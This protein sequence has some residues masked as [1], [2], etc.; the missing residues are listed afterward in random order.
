MKRHLVSLTLAASVLAST[1]LTAGAAEPSP[2]P[3]LPDTRFGIAEGF[4]NPTAMADIRAGWQRLVFSWSDIQPNGP[5]DFSQLGLS[6]PNDRLQAELDRGSRVAGLLQFTPGWAQ[7]NPG[8]GQRSVPLNLDLPFDDPN[9]Y[10]GRYVYETVKYYNGRINEWIIWNEP[11]FRETDAGAGGSFTWKGTDEEFAQ[12]LKVGYLA[13]K[14][15]NPNATVSFPGTS[16]WVEELASPRRPQF[17]DRVLDILSRDPEAARNNQYHD[18]VSLNLY[19]APDDVFRVHAVFKAIQQKYG[20]DKPIWLTETNAMPSDDSSVPCANRHADVPIKTTMDQQASYAMQ[21][22]ALAAAAGYQRIEFYQMVDGGT[23]QEPAIWG[24]TR[25]NGSRRPVADALRTSVSYYSGYT[26]AQ[27]V[28][29]AREVQR[30]PT[31]PDDPSSY[32]PNW[33]VYQVA[34][35][36]PGSQRVT[37]LWN[38]DGSALRARIKKTGSSARVVERDGSERPLLENQG[39]W[40]VDL[41]AAT[42]YFQLNDVIKDPEGFYF[43]GGQPLLIV[44]EGVA[45]AAPVTQPRLGEP[46]SAQRDFNIVVSPMDQSL[47]LGEPAEFYLSS[48]GREDFSDPIQLRVVSW[49]S[50]RFPDPKDGSSLPLGVSLQERIN[51]GDEA[52][53][54]LET[55]GADPGIYYITLEASGG[56]ITRTMELALA[57]S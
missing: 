40:V 3:S 33:Q 23:C 9:N 16:Y 11:E 45:A 7:R 21:S 53:L 46:G 15:A 19:R 36:R 37:A 38:G 26:Q 12:L 35:D 27:F 41:P 30:W 25:D 28:P 14:R 52:T 13:A 54:R 43:I 4:R 47:G 1:A 31:W 34:F 2:A 6:L 8:D 24:V 5:G 57:L 18:V 10:F 49:S 29:L 48:F 50:Q 20:L 17:Y 51:P 55:A 56:G 44:E 22:F 32:T 39:W 42:A